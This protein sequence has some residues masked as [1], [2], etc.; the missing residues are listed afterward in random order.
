MA[1]RAEAR[2]YTGPEPEHG[3]PLGTPKPEPKI[4][5]DYEH[6]PLSG[7]LAD[8]ALKARAEYESG[9]IEHERVNKV[10]PLYNPYDNAVTNVSVNMPGGIIIEVKVG[11]P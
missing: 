5:L 8:D 7:T 6:R 3:T 4:N 2:T 9:R 11:R 1:A 10:P